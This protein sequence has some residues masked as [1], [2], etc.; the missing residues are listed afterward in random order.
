MKIKTSI[1]LEQDLLAAIDQ[2]ACEYGSR[3]GFLETAARRLLD[4]LLKEQAELRDLDILNRR[5]DALNQEAAGVLEYQ[6][7]L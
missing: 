5:A 2:Q 3:S 1:T 7:P 4:R 6:E